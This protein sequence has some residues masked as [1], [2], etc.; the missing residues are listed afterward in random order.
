MSPVAAA[1]L[2]LIGSDIFKTFAGSAHLKNLAGRPWYVAAL[3]VLAAVYFV[4]GSPGST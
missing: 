2:L 1:T 3:C 4:F